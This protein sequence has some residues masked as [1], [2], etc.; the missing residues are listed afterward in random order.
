M[1]MVIKN[2]EL[3]E[4]IKKAVKEAMEEEALKLRLE[5]LPHV[6][7]KEQQEI[8]KLFGKEPPKEKDVAYVEE[9]DV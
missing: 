6:T 2:Q 1:E 8:E 5:M 7:D 4:L 9:I 3:Y